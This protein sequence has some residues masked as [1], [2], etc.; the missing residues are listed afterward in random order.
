MGRDPSWMPKLPSEGKLHPKRPHSLSIVRGR[1]RQPTTRRGHLLG[2]RIIRAI[3]TLANPMDLDMAAVLL[4]LDSSRSIST[5]EQQFR[6]VDED[7]QA[8]LRRPPIGAFSKSAL[9]ARETASRRSHAALR[10]V[11][12]MEQRKQIRRISLKTAGGYVAEYD[13]RHEKV[14]DFTC[15]SHCWR[16]ISRSGSNWPVRPLRRLVRLFSPRAPPWMPPIAKGIPAV[17]G[18]GSTTT[19]KRPLPAAPALAFSI[20]RDD[21][22]WLGRYDTPESYAAVEGIRSSR[23]A[24]RRDPG[25]DARRALGHRGIAAGSRILAAKDAQSLK[26]AVRD[27]FVKKGAHHSDPRRRRSPVRIPGFG[28][29]ALLCAAGQR[30]LSAVTRGGLI[31]RASRI[32]ERKLVVVNPQPEL[33]PMDRDWSQVEEWARTLTTQDVRV[34]ETRVLFRLARE[35][36]GFADRSF[37]PKVMQLADPRNDALMPM[38]GGSP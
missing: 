20:R 1:S 27:L 16:P 23:R 11:A 38:N 4:S 5:R 24:A 25:G 35:E 21:P 15:I 12:I 19:A 29:L 2:S 32:A 28:S 18:S 22:P 7:C 13:F 37:W 14:S 26:S 33:D 30:A 6:L 31:S 10:Y 9:E 17:V 34:L 36:G 3:A 8:D